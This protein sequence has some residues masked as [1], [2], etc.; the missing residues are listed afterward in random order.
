MSR[1]FY[2]WWIIIASSALSTYNNGILYY[3]FTAFFNPVVNEFGWSRAA[4]AFAFS[5]KRLEGGI[6]APIVGFFIDK[7]G[8][9]KM[10]LFAVT[11]YGAG[12][13][14]LSRVDSLLTFY[15]SFIP[16]SWSPLRYS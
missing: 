5:L 2:G 16:V 9:R 8:P 14:L 10:S 7:L 12:F 13:L 3:G 11:I 1:I 4:T 15:I 6:A